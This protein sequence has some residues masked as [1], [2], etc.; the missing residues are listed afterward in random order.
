VSPEWTPPPPA[1]PNGSPEAMFW[2]YATRRDLRFQCC[3]EC[4]TYRHPPS[5]LC[6]TCMSAEFDFR[7]ALGPAELFSW[8][9]IHHSTFEYHSVTPFMVACALFSRHRVR[10]VAG[11]LKRSGADP[12]IG[13]PLKIVWAQTSDGASLPMLTRMTEP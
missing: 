7:P 4:G 6:Q 2:S 12:V 5:T 3:C 10:F 13:D 8:T 11:Y 9:R 1:P